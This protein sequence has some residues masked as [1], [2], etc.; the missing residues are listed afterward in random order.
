QE[1]EQ[2]ILPQAIR[3]KL[4]FYIHIDSNCSQLFIGARDQLKQIIINLAGNAV[5]FTEQ[6]HVIL[7]VRVVSQT[8]YKQQLI[9]EVEDTGIGIPAEIQHE[10]FKP[11]IQADLS[12]TRKYG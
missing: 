10:I 8:A 4:R 9:F 1:I 6:G 12:I 2:I 11:F 7:S 3:K 5:K